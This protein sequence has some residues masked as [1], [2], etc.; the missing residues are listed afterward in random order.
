MVKEEKWKTNYLKNINYNKVNDLFILS[1]QKV[2]AIDLFV[3]G[4]SVQGYLS[5]GYIS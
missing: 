4:V 1:V 5:R 2:C 3:Q